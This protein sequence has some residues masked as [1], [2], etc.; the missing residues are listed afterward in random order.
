MKRQKVA[1]DL[2]RKGFVHRHR[3][4]CQIAYDDREVPPGPHLIAAIRRYDPQLFFRKNIISMRWEVWRWRDGFPPR[5]SAAGMTPDGILAGSVFIKTVQTFDGKYCDPDV[6]VLEFLVAT[7][8]FAK[9][10]QTVDQIADHMDNCS[11]RNLMKERE[12]RRE[13]VED[14]KKDNRYQIRSAVG[15]GRFISVPK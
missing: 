2:L 11:T 9:G 3:A 14:W 6:R 15:G 7:D 5:E 4:D 13:Y 8:E 12:E 10:R 1:A